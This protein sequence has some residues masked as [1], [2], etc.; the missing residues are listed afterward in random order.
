LFD[1]EPPS[2]EDA[3][4]SLNVD[5]GGFNSIAESKNGKQDRFKAVTYTSSSDKVEEDTGFTD[6]LNSWMVG[7][8]E[9]TQN[10]ASNVLN[11]TLTT[12]TI[13]AETSSQILDKGTEIASSETVRSF[14]TK[15]ND[16]INFVINKLFGGSKKE[17][18]KEEKKSGSENVSIDLNNN[19]KIKK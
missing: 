2:K 13:V 15:A 17:D 7:A 3:L 4:K 9:G 11:R 1:R 12:T 10:I 8:L 18:I 5:V 19:V 14:A 16:G 6:S